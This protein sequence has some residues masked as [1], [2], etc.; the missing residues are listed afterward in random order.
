MFSNLYS[1]YNKSSRG[2]LIVKC[3]SIKVHNSITTNWVFK[4]IIYLFTHYLSMKDKV[5]KD[6]LS[7]H[8]KIVWACLLLE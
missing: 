1:G 5:Q 6:Y 4:D 7:T 8:F 3:T 2:L